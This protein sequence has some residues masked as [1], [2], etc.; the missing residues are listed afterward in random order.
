MA[1]KIS[2]FSLTTLQDGDQ[3]PL[4]RSG[5]PSSDLRAPLFTPSTV[6]GAGRTDEVPR[7][8]VARTQDV[9]SIKD[10]GAVGDNS[11]LNDTAIAAAVAEVLTAD[12]KKALWIPAGIFRHSGTLNLRDVRVIDGPG[13]LRYTGAGTAIKAGPTSTSIGTATS[14]YRMYLRCEAL[15]LANG[16][17]GIELPMLN[18]SFAH[19]AHCQNFE[20]GLHIIP[21]SGQQLINNQIVLGAFEFCRVGIKFEPSGTGMA[22]DNR[23]F[24]GST[25]GTW[26]PGGSRYGF[27]AT[28]RFHTGVF[29]SPS[30][31][32]GDGAAILLE[33]S[34]SGSRFLHTRLE[35]SGPPT[36]NDTAGGNIVSAKYPTAE[37][38]AQAGVAYAGN[39]RRPNFVYWDA[40][41]PVWVELARLDFRS[42]TQDPSTGEWTAP[43]LFVSTGSGSATASVLA[44]GQVVIDAANETFQIISR[45]IGFKIN[46]S[47]GQ[48]FRV[49]A[50]MSNPAT[51]GELS[52]LALDASGVKLNPALYSFP[53][54]DGE[55]ATIVSGGTDWARN[56]FQSVNFDAHFFAHKA[57]HADVK[58]AYVQIIPGTY[59]EFRVWGLVDYYSRPLPV[60]VSADTALQPGDL[61]KVPS[62]AVS[63]VP[64]AAS[65]G[66]GSMI[67][68]TNGAAGLP[69]LAI[70]D[71]TNWLRC[72]TLAGI[73]SI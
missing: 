4:Y 59:R 14:H 9:V 73:S 52:F 33:G 56:Q 54:L 11:T 43:G 19:F 2:D 40:H 41:G 38:N 3:A 42:F 36:F 17:K 31:E 24:G 51:Q 55:R 69:V 44:S 1:L 60:A 5:S 21:A 46:V 65:E 53:L 6:Y 15:T 28:D 26:S 13:L 30:F 18:S 63:G 64:S 39:S 45:A 37:Q 62:F 25:G 32:S 27:W 66:A 58:T 70:S 48:I 7:T 23:F 47:A 50:T 34:S 12:T 68:V 61:L 35:T 71:G 67:F 29:F 72:D 57:A 22:N 49:L 10:F 8:L 16:T 20:I